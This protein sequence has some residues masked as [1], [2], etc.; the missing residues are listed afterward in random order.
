MSD[1]IET[2]EELVDEVEEKEHV[3]GELTPESKIE[4][5]VYRTLKAKIKGY[6]TVTLEAKDEKTENDT[7]HVTVNS[8]RI[9][10]TKD[11]ILPD[12]SRDLITQSDS[13]AVVL[14]H[15][16]FDDFKKF[17]NSRFFYKE[18][19]PKQQPVKR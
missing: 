17:I 19:K 12:E 14:A 10:Y 3:N 8:N 2:K 4:S 15:L 18:T 16:V 9:L 7:L 11:M 1:V 13:M 6:I 5:V